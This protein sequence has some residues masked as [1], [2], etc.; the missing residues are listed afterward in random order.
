MPLWFLARLALRRVRAATVCAKSACL[1]KGFV[2]ESEW[3]LATKTPLAFAVRR[4]SL[5]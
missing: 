3:F 4:P 5:R 1:G 2:A